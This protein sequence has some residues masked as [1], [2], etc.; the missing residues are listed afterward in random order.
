M[1]I[2]EESHSLHLASRTELLVP[3]GTAIPRCASS[4]RLRQTLFLAPGFWLW[5]GFAAGAL[6]FDGDETLGVGFVFEEREF[7]LG[8]AGWEKRDAR[9]DQGRNDAQ[10]EFINQIEL[11]KVADELTTAHEP[12]VFAGLTANGLDDFFRRISGEDDAVALT[13][14]KRAREDVGGEAV[15]VDLFAS[16]HFEADFIGFASHQSRVDGLEESAHGVVLGHE[17]EVDGT[18]GAGDIAIEGNAE[19]EN[20][21]AHGWHSNKD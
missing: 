2:A 8:K 20:N 21:A 10:I 3:G 15:G 6:V 5:L 18:V 17:Q 4:N 13:S 16:G 1:R 7:A 9:S 19:A 11:E 14:R 12:D